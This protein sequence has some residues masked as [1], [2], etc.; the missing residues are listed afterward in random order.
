A[1]GPAPRDYACT[2]LAAVVDNRDAA[3]CQVGDGAIVMASAE[4]PDEFNWIFWPQHG[5]YANQ[6]NF[7][8]QANAALFLNH[9]ILF[10]RQG[11]VEEIFVFTDGI[12][13]LVLDLAKQIVHQPFYRAFARPLR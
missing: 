7:A 3:F 8:S 10:E 11:T 13:R 6:T 5:E 2:L 9:E 1:E 4:E 12:E